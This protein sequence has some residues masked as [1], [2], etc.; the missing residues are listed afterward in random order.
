M[1]KGKMASA[2]LGL[3][4]GNAI[5]AHM[6]GKADKNGRYDVQPACNWAASGDMALCLAQSLSKGLDY[7]DIASR[8]LRWMRGECLAPS[9]EEIVIDPRTRRALMRFEVGKDAVKCGASKRKNNR[10]QPLGWA[11]PLAFYRFDTPAAAFE[12]VKNTIGI[13][14]GDA[15]CVL[16]CAAFIETARN[17]I[18]GKT[19]QE[20]WDMAGNTVY[21]AY[22]NGQYSREYVKEALLFKHR[23]FLT[24]Q[25]YGDLPKSCIVNEDDPMTTLDA[26]IWCLLN[27]VSFQ[28]TVSKAV[29]FGGESGILC[30][31]VGGLSGLHYGMENIPP[32]WQDALVRKEEVFAVALEW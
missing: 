16:A 1:E 22:M 17:I 15:R 23:L 24:G 13:T 5:G 21:H 8:F 10:T 20:S 14:H 9:G 18:D 7:S 2:L 25:Q 12:T 4:V 32:K 6:A 30:A 27:G 28:D 19:L 26:A 31:A 11:L 3:C 29:S